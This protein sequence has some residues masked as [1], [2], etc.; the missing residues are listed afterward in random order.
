M[1]TAQ[2]LALAVQR[3]KAA[4]VP[5]AANDAR[6]LLAH[7]LGID[8]SRLT[9]VLPDEIP[10]ETAA[11]FDAIITR[12]ANR[13]PVSQIIGRREFYGRDFIVTPDVLDPRPETE[14]L[15]EAALAAPFE[16]VLDLGT[17]SGCILLTLLAE[18]AMATGQG[19]DISD[20]ALDVA[21]RNAA[22][23]D[24]GTRSR[25]AT[26]NWFKAVSGTFDLIVSN[27]PY[28]AAGEMPMLAPD[29]RNWEPEIALSPGGDGLA[30]Y[31]KII[32]TAPQHLNAKGRLLVEI[33]YRQGKAVKAL[34][35]SAGFDGITIVQ[36]INGHD[37]VI[38]GHLA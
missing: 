33:G 34:F 24:L 14:L 11:A 17:G 29:V 8:R 5:D 2:A 32:A 12:R 20:A 6:I 27:P 13:Q 15:I 10:P 23:L 36:D 4:D 37:R 16:T 18:N 26:S 38:C 30:S 7:A 19:V 28:I 35:Q 31:R 22:R 25:F 3:L 1:T 9:L 21:R